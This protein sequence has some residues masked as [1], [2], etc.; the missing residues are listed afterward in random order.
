MTV[1]GFEQ[2]VFFLS[3][4]W[5]A[6]YADKE[7]LSVPVTFWNWRCCL[8]HGSD[9]RAPKCWAR[10]HTQNG[11][12]EASN[13]EP[14]GYL[15]SSKTLSFSFKRE[16]CFLDF[17]YFCTRFRRHVGGQDD[18][19]PHSLTLTDIADCFNFASLS[20]FSRYV[21]NNLGASPSSFR[22]WIW[23]VFSS[24]HL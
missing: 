11:K 9:G 15:L 5:T 13:S 12:T 22:E 23:I 6:D 18:Q 8:V 10:L 1:N 19:D 4:G 3:V 20:H 14:S 16:H 17:P 2:K 21:P 24:K 7:V